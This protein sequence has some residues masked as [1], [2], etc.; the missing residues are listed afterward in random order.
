M[1]IVLARTLPRRLQLSIAV[2][3][4]IPASL[5]LAF[6]PLP[7]LRSIVVTILMLALAC[8]AAAVTRDVARRR[9][10]IDARTEL[11][12]AADALAEA[13]AAE[14]AHADAKDRMAESL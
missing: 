7:A 11:R 10:L 4:L 6:F 2:G 12:Q 8:L 5:F 9:E 13:R 3:I 14:R 1:T